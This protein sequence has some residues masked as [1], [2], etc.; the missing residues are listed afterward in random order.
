MKKLLVI[1]L[2]LGVSACATPPPS[3]LQAMPANTA[4]QADAVRVVAGQ[5]A[6]T[7]PGNFGGYG[8][9]W[10]LMSTIDDSTGAV[11]DQ[12]EVTLLYIRPG[13]AFFSSATDGHAAPLTVLPIALQAN[14]CGND[15]CAFHETVSVMLPPGELTESAKSG[16]QVKIAAQ[17][18][19]SFAMDITPKMIQQQLTAVAA[20]R[21]ALVAQSQPN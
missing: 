1:L 20:A 9:I 2:A 10:R 5:A 13:W 12:L 17:D 3:Q 6:T 19:T 4:G 11:T 8:R 16:F 15:A 18:G 21:P 7:V 14:G